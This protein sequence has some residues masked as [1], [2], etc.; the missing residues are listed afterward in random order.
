MGFPS[1]PVITFMM[2]SHISNSNAAATSHNLRH[3]PDILQ[4]RVFQIG[5]SV[6]F[7]HRREDDGVAGLLLLMPER[8]RLICPEKNKDAK[9]LFPC[10]FSASLSPSMEVALPLLSILPPKG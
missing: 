10:A 3:M 1:F 5:R 9:S 6:P 8:R 4:R 7:C 2:N